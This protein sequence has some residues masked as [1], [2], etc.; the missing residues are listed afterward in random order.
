M[1]VVDSPEGSFYLVH[2]HLGLAERERHWQALHL[3]EHGLFRQSSSLP[4]L[5]VGDFNDWRNTLAKGP[6][7]THGFH[8]LTAPRSRFRSFP[9]YWPVAAIDKAFARG[10]LAVR[11]V[12]IAHSRLARDASDHLPLVIDFH[13]D[14]THPTGRLDGQHKAP[15]AP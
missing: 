3:L 5:I 10:H 6:M 8:Q 13:L 1:A 4:T 14:K 11:H 7:A 9:A 2:W 12:R 15:Y